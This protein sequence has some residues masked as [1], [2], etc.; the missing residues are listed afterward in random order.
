MRIAERGLAFFLIVAAAV[1]AY[2]RWSYATGDG[3]VTVITDRWYTAFESSFTFADIWLAI[4]AALAGVGLWLD[5]SWAARFGLMAGSAFLYLAALDITF[6]I[7]NGM[8]ALAAASDAMKFE[9]FINA[10]SIILGV[11]SI[12]V[13]WRR[14]G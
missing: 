9:I 12:V 7:E 1:T 8:Y 4:C 14:L 3:G 6:N 5:R 11:W 10:S 13:S 2:Y